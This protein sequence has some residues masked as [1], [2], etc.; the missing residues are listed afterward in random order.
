MAR[1]SAELLTVPDSIVAA[2]GIER[3][4]YCLAICSLKA[5]E[6]PEHVIASLVVVRRD[7]D[8]NVTSFDC[9]QLPREMEVSEDEEALC[10]SFVVG[11]AAVLELEIVL[12]EQ[13]RHIN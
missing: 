5:W 9:V 11:K 3:R 12:L 2:P 7:D 13:K 8:Q 4:R 1:P 6:C 10:C